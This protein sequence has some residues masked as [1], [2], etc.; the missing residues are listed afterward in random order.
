[1]NSVRLQFPPPVS[2]T[3]ND[4]PAPN[5]A[6]PAPSSSS[7]TSPSVFSLSR[8]VPRRESKS[9]RHVAF[10]IAFYYLL[11]GLLWVVGSNYLVNLF[12]PKDLAT[13]SH[14][15][16]V[17]GIFFV[18]LTASLLFLLVYHLVKQIKQTQHVMQTRLEGIAE[19]YQR[20][21]LRSPSAMLIFDPQTR[22]ILAV[23]DVA[24]LLYGYSRDELLAMKTLD[25]VVEEERSR[26]MALS[27]GYRAQIIRQVGPFQVR[28][29]DGRIIFIEGVTHQ[30]EFDGKLV[31]IAQITDIT[32]RLQ[33]ERSLAQYRTQLE[34]RVTERTAELSQAN[35]QLREEVRERQRIED[36]LRAATAEAEAANEAKSAFLANTSHEIRTPL[37]S[38]LGYA[39][40]L[41]EETLSGTDRAKFL[42]VVKHN[43]QHLLGLIDDVLDLS[44]AEMGHA[45]VSQERVSPREIALQ[46]IEQLRPRAQEKSLNLCLNMAD[47]LPE[48]IYTDGVRLRQILLNLLSNAIKFTQN[49]SVGLSLMIFHSELDA[50]PTIRFDVADTG[51]GLSPEHLERVFEPF[52][53]VEANHA[54]RVGGFGLG[55][56]ISRQLAIRLGGLL[57]VKSLPG[58]GS[59]FSLLLPVEGLAGRTDD[60]AGSAARELRNSPATLS[61][62]PQ[63]AVEVKDVTVAPPVPPSTGAILNAHIL[64]AEDN[65]NI[66][67]LVDEYLTRAGA[68]VTAVA[69]GAEA[70]ERVRVSL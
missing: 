18:F 48:T 51:I 60:L 38:I 58:V 30:V 70:V 26:A 29:R 35:R 57:S 13:Y 43:A 7:I 4:I 50:D 3:L 31:R 21:F 34:Q 46:T 69:N 47:E 14:F 6:T 68:R 27:V 33:T 65:P 10:R 28:R 41:A 54:R 22:R 45:R 52:F 11:F 39:D 32:E 16:T 64:L 63:A 53:Q 66:R 15:Q 56:A 20:L 62:S 61:A 44:R 25:L 5:A 67:L 17:K 55:L 1:M 49:G 24:L 42:N 19:Q 12:V 36:E 37:T 2:A 40:L 8:A 9:H 23:N 59:T